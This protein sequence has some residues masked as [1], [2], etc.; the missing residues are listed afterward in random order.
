MS[1]FV[2]S[3]VSRLFA[4]AFAPRPKISREGAYLVIQSGWR[5]A[6]WT[7]GGRKRRVSVDPVSKIV[8]IHDRTFWFFSNRQVVSFD[9]VQ[10][11]IYSYTDLMD[12]NWYSHTTEDLFRVGFWL[13]DGKSVILFRFYGEGEFVNNSIW[14]DWMMWGDILPGEIIHNNMESESATLSELLSGMIGVP[15]GNGPI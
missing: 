10:E 2:G 4:K 1:D 7:L 13:K 9:R 3:I 15:I 14:P 6:F 5:T 11:I 8:H 12:S